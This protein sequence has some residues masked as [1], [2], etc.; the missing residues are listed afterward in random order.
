MPALFLTLALGTSAAQLPAAALSEPSIVLEQ[1]R[2]QMHDLDYVRAIA[3][4]RQVQRLDPENPAGYYYEAATAWLRELDRR[5]DLNLGRFLDASYFDEKNTRPRD[6]AAEKTINDM[7]TLFILISCSSKV[8][9]AL[10]YIQ[11]CIV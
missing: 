10:P 6:E 1:G 11:R 8:Y 9:R 4:F 3:S 5:E 7:Y 2:R